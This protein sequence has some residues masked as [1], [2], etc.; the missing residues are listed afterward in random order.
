LLINRLLPVWIE[1]GFLQGRIYDDVYSPGAFLQPE[2]VRYARARAL[3]S[4]IHGL[5][6]AEDAIE[7]CNSDASSWQ[8]LTQSPER[9]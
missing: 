6:E 9:E 4:E 5:M 8:M 3:L 2:H 1:G 7:V